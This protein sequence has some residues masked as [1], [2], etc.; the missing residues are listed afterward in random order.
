MRFSTSFPPKNAFPQ[1][2]E[3]FLFPHTKI[4]NI[5]HIDNQLIIFLSLFHDSPYI[6][7]DLTY[8]QTNKLRRGIKKRGK[9][10][11]FP[12]F[13]THKTICFRTALW[14]TWDESIVSGSIFRRLMIYNTLI[15]GRIHQ[16]ICLLPLLYMLHGLYGQ[17]Q[18]E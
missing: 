7:Y 1:H 11:N 14:K 10:K 16:S 3:E 4:Q 13:C 18:F 6:K 2:S 9:L 15:W 17:T 12:R 5:Y 8:Q